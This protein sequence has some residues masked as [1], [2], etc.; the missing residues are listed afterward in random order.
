MCQS[1]I[2]IEDTPWSINEENRMLSQFFTPPIIKKICVNIVEP[3]L[4]QIGDDTETI[5]N[6]AVGI[7]KSKGE[8]RQYCDYRRN[9]SNS[10]KKHVE[11]I[12][13]RL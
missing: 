6:L 7:W 8:N 10:V 9:I 2:D 4:T 11:D 3:I 13:N 5:L 1:I 12:L